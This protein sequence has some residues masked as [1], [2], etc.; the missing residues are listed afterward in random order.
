MYSY[1]P[2]TIRVCMYTK[3]YLTFL[4]I[5]D[6]FTR[7]ERKCIYSVYTRERRIHNGHILKVLLCPFLSPIENIGVCKLS[8]YHVFCH[9]ASTTVASIIK[10]RCTGSL[11]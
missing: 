3:G 8:L 4:S 6:T 2:C 1:F 11:G 5:K 7:K 9:R 10:G